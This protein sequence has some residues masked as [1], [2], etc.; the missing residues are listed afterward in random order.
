MKR[1]RWG[2]AGVLAGLVLICLLL[3]G[4]FLAVREKSDDSV[5]KGSAEKVSVENVLMGESTAYESA[6][7][8]ENADG[9]T[10]GN[11][12]ESDRGSTVV[13][14]PEAEQEPG[15][16]EGD[17][18]G[19]TIPRMVQVDG[20][21]YYDTGMIS[22]VVGCGMMDGEITS[23][24]S[25]DEVPSKDN[26]SNFGADY[27]Y[28]RGGH[29]LIC[30]SMDGAWRIFQASEAYRLTITNG[31]TGEL[32]ELE[33]SPEFWG[34]IEKY[35]NL[36]MVKEENQEPRTGYSY[37][38]RLFDEAGG[39]LNTVSVSGQKLEE[40]G[41][42]YMDSGY[43]TV[44]EL[45]LLLDSYYEEDAVEA[46]AAKPAEGEIDTLEEVSMYVT[47]ATNKGVS[48]VFTNYSDRELLFGE[49][50][51][52]Q[53]RKGDTWYEVD[54]IIDNWGF[55]A[56]GYML[57]KGQPVCWG[58]KW[59]GFHGVLPA[60]EYRLVKEVLESGADGTGVTARYRLAAEFEVE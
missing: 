44:V 39:L 22:D 38:L 32:V 15:L 31:T 33:R 48:A 17:T 25:A 13:I 60:G 53:Q 6:F 10:V 20:E 41:V 3:V 7:A 58:T 40:N 19:D 2:I 27:G 28:Q 24:V 35:N 16:M 36:D 30:V 26:Q 42:Y 56:I 4:L 5:E 54:Y 55:V 43:G 49:E 11:G 51:E 57:P 29:K 1:R 14:C 23:T 59:T 50:Y 52:L 37:C 46:T 12:K 45:W 34:I 9:G 21:L 8:R 18:E 47:Y